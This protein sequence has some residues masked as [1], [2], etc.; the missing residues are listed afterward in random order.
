[1]S[2]RVALQALTAVAAG[3]VTALGLLS[4]AG[5][6]AAVAGYQDAYVERYGVMTWTP[7]TVDPD[8]WTTG[9]R[10]VLESDITFGSPFRTSGHKET[11][12]G[13]VGQGGV[14]YFPRYEY[15]YFLSAHDVGLG[16]EGSYYC[17]LPQCVLDTP[18]PEYDNRDYALISAAPEDIVAY[19]TY[20]ADVYVIDGPVNTAYV[21]HISVASAIH[22]DCVI[23]EAFCTFENYRHYINKQRELVVNAYYGAYQAGSYVTDNTFYPCPG[24]WGFSAGNVD[25]WCATDSGGPESPGRATIRPKSGQ[26]SGHAFRTVS[27]SVQL[28]GPGDADN[29]SVEYLV[30]CLTGNPCHGYLGHQ[31]RNSG[32]YVSERRTPDFSIPNDGHWYLCRFDTKF[33]VTLDGGNSTE[34]EASGN[35]LRV[36]LGNGKAGTQLRIDAMAILGF[37]TYGEYNQDP[38]LDRNQCNR[39][40]EPGPVWW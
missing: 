38:Y 11:T 17:T 9:T 3:F 34:V 15:Q 39:Y 28:V 10:L 16:Y 27:F 1:M 7:T 13:P 31:V 36:L 26:S 30:Q 6:T 37:N 21:Q 40:I 33:D 19:G 4:G 20:S 12:P 18:F 25:Y 14:N 5:P 32:S 24:S 35:Q 29:F 22:S 2:W 8:S 23:G